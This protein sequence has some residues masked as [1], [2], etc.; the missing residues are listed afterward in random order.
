MAGLK[1]LRS[2]IYHCIGAVGPA[3]GAQTISEINQHWSPRGRLSAHSVR[4][5]SS[6]TS[7]VVANTGSIGGVRAGVGACSKAPSTGEPVDEHTGAFG[8]LRTELDEIDHGIVTRLARRQQW[9][10]PLAKAN[11]S[12]GAQGLMIEIHP[13]PADVL[14][15][16]PQALTSR[17]LPI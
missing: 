8:D 14:S 16:G 3:S 12:A 10:P 2:T 17:C 13:S 9:V 1:L 11:I 7:E 6:F 4:G 15:D 5:T